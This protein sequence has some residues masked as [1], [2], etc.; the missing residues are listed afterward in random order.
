MGTAG[1]IYE[2]LSEV[3]A[4]CTRGRRRCGWRAAAAVGDAGQNYK[5]LA[6]LWRLFP[7]PLSPFEPVMGCG[8][9]AKADTSAAVEAKRPR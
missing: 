1:I 6:M 5:N 2:L 8:I 4:G 3:R 9:K 7:S